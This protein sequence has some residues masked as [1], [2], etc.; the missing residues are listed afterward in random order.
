M[1]TIKK[2]LTWSVPKAEKDLGD[3]SKKEGKF[4]LIGMFGQNIIY[5]II[6]AALSLFYTDVLLVPIATIGI[7]F[8]AARVWDALNDPVMGIIMD[9]TKTR[10]GKAR[11]Y[12]KYM[13]F[14]VAIV[15]LALFMPISSWSMGGIIAYLVVMYFLWS[16]VYTLCD[17]PLWSLPSLM[18]PDE[19]RRTK[20]ISMA[21][22][23]G[24]IGGI[25]IAI[26]APMKNALGKIDLGLFENVGLPNY[27]G[28]FSQ[29][30][31]YLFT[32]LILVI[33]GAVLFK[34]V[35]PNTRERVKSNSQSLTIKESLK[36]VG[37]NKP[38]LMILASGVLGSTKMLLMTAGMYFCKWV[39]GNGD[40]GLWIVYLGAPFLIGQFVALGLTPKLGRLLGKKKLYIMSSYLS[41]VPNLILF[42]VG[43]N[44]LT[45]LHEPLILSF[46]IVMLMFYGFFAG[47]SVALQ[48]IM[49]A[50]SVDYLEWRDGVR[51][52]GVFFSGLTFMAKLT[53]GI[54]ILISNILLGFVDYTDQ[55]AVLTEQMKQA[56]DSGG[57]YALNFAESYPKMT[58]MMFVLITIVPA[59]GCVLQ[60]VVMHGYKLT[61]D[62]MKNVRNELSVKRE[63]QESKAL[64]G[65]ETK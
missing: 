44:L 34:F 9:K 22:I 13:P 24:S 26:Y 42:L 56:V 6:S 55:I 25:V 33:I 12:L 35:F 14:P 54:A 41:L 2:I 46:I 37:K 8:T 23:V 65:E 49:I 47:F 19:E 31:G 45:R 36:Q 63:E 62:Y 5:S 40:E 57:N 50:D 3:Y 17:I 21:R 20:L 64:T 60:G 1:N 39:M 18:V 7:I 32:T 59:I 52:D 53:S 10:W 15:T 29:E 48:P 28:Y 11:P 30:Q 61:D 16:P 27:D 43:M 38:F 51:A 4:F 58:M